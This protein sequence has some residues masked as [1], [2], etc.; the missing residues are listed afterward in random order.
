MKDLFD[1]SKRKAGTFEF[2]NKGENIIRVTL[3]YVAL[4]RNLVHVITRRF[5]RISP[6]KKFQAKA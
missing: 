4:S 3:E 5:Y 6:V 1:V 2:V